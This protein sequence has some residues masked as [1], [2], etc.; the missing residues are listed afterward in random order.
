[1]NENRVFIVSFGSNT[2][3][4]KANAQMPIYKTYFENQDLDT[5]TNSQME[6]IIK[7][8]VGSV[9]YLDKY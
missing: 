7:T 6:E 5:L 2:H 9:F 1:M 8:I 4:K 3:G